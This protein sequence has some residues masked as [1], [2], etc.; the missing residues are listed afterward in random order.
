M[1]SPPTWGSGALTVG[2]GASLSIG[3][4][5]LGNMVQTL[6]T[7]LALSLDSCVVSGQS[8]GSDNLMNL[9]ADTIT[10][11]DVHP[12]DNAWSLDA[13][14]GVYTITVA[15]DAAEPSIQVHDG[16]T[17]NIVGDRSL[18][19]PPTW[20]NG[21][22]VAGTLTGDWVVFTGSIGLQVG[23]ASGSAIGPPAPC[24]GT[25][26]GGSPPPPP[27][28]TGTSTGTP[29]AATLTDCALD[30]T[31]ESAFVGGGAATSTSNT[32][33]RVPTRQVSPG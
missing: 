1:L 15:A 8:P 18:S 16:R 12:A 25:H 24:F 3:Y 23:P 26:C 33:P 32:C 28:A 2:E 13:A 22:S 10:F 4:V 14:D 6:S 19:S 31:G 21:P 27:D 17:V 20:G 9:V 7:A 29:A 30:F 11:S 5:Q